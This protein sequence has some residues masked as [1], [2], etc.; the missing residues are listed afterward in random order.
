[1]LAPHQP[2]DAPDRPNRTEHPRTENRID[3]RGSPCEPWT[4]G[5]LPGESPGSARDSRRT[6]APRG[7]GA[8]ARASGAHGVYSYEG[9][10]NSFVECILIMRLHAFLG[11]MRLGC[12]ASPSGVRP[13]LFGVY[14]YEGLHE[15]FVEC[16]LMCFLWAMRL[17]FGAARAIAAGHT[18]GT[19]AISPFPAGGG[20][21]GRCG[22]V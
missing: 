21:G 13:A 22:C 11:A 6:R 5:P 16:V 20:V 18:F 7:D 17:G 2:S 15:S 9:L 1:M 10:Q 12:V 4:L 14:S 3:A 19:G 8:L